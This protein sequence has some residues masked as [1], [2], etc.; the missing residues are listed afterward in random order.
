[1]ALTAAQVLARS[2]ALANGLIDTDTSDFAEGNH[3]ELRTM[4][5]A[6]N[7]S[8][9]LM[10]KAAKAV[11]IMARWTEVPEIPPSSRARLA[12]LGGGAVEMAK[13]AMPSYRRI[14]RRAEIE[15]LQAIANVGGFLELVTKQEIDAF[16]EGI[17]TGSR[18]E[19]LGLVEQRVGREAYQMIR[20]EVIKAL[21][22]ERR[23]AE[24]EQLIEAD[25][26][27]H[28]AAARAA[29]EFEIKLAAAAA[30]HQEQESKLAE[31][32]RILEAR[33]AEARALEEAERLRNQ[34]K[35]SNNE[36]ALERLAEN[37]GA[38]R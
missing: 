12:K 3:R 21:E 35:A 11:Q 27:P 23:I 26:E 36:A 30:T 16:R 10:A 18:S 2:V 1:M 19:T 9:S 38:K 7:V 22:A 14:M 25:P 13:R 31:A 4:L 8:D 28:E 34:G 37:M 29:R 32:E 5:A 33:T 17:R 6:L 24:L 15:N 20:H